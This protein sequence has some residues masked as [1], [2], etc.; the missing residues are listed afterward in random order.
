MKR[1]NITSMDGRVDTAIIQRRTSKKTEAKANPMKNTAVEMQE[2]IQTLNVRGM[3]DGIAMLMGMSLV[4]ATC[5]RVAVEAEVAG[6]TV[7]VGEDAVDEVGDT[8]AAAPP[9]GQVADGLMAEEE[10]VMLAMVVIAAPM[11]GSTT[12]MTNMTIALRGDESTGR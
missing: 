8:A 11:D 7:E 6:T 2:D 10:E 1:W 4:L 3:Q 12:I 9:A 5:T